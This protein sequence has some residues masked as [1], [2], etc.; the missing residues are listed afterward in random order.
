MRNL[1]QLY[2]LV[3]KMCFVFFFP[4]HEISHILR[5]PVCLTVQRSLIKL[6]FHSHLR[7]LY[8]ISSFKLKHVVQEEK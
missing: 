7:I 3:L 4:V 5:I 1:H 6:Y 8:T 2:F